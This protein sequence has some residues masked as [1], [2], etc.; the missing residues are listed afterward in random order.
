[1]AEKIEKFASVDKPDS[2]K[3]SWQGFSKRI[4]DF[5]LPGVSP[6]ELD[7]KLIETAMKKNGK[8]AVFTIRFTNGK[9]IAEVSCVGTVLTVAALDTNKEKDREKKRNL[10]KAISDR[11]ELVSNA[12]LQ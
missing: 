2:L 9:F 12:D 8:P 11:S 4:K 3:I 5:A 7:W 1:M 10:L 6:R